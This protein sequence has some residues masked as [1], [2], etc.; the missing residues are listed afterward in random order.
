MSA[1][2]LVSDRGMSVPP[3]HTVQTAYVDIYE[4]RMACR[5]RMAVGDVDRAFQKLIQLGGNSPFPSPYGRWLE[6]GAFEI[7][8]GRHEF[9]A[10]LMLGKTHILVAWIQGPRL[11]DA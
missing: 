10:S 6:D 11:N 9:I 4:I 3:G 7:I 1:L 8:D 2:A 5:E